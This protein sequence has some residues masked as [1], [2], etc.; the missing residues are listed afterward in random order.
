[1]S[2][3]PNRTKTADV[4]VY[5]DFYMDESG[6]KLPILVDVKYDRH[7]ND[8]LDVQVVSEDFEALTWVRWHS[9]NNS[10]HEEAWGISDYAAWFKEHGEAHDK[11]YRREMD[12]IRAEALR[13]CQL[14]EVGLDEYLSG[15]DKVSAEEYEVA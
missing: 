15:S 12:Q 8:I 6:R 14:D 5:L 2:K 13:V 10:D 11:Q 9:S 7:T 4:I 3:K 1:M